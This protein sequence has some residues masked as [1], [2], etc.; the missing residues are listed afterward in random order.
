MSLIFE[1]NVSTTVAA[2]VE[3]VY[4]DYKLRRVV[5]KIGTAANSVAYRAICVPI[6]A[7]GSSTLD[8]APIVLQEA[9]LY[10]LGKDNAVNNFIDRLEIITEAVGQL[11]GVFV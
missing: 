7:N 11:Q 5:V 9:N 1:A 8:T 10:G 3:T 6:D 2:T 4:P